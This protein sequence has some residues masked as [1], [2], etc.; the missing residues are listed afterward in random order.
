MRDAIGLLTRQHAWISAAVIVLVAAVANT[1]GGS[2]IDEGLHL[3]GLRD[4]LRFAVGVIGG[5]WQ[6][7]FR[8]IKSDLEYYGVL[9]IL[10][11]YSA[12][13]LSQVLGASTAEY[14]L[15]YRLALH[16][17]ALVW[18]LAAAWATFKIVEIVSGSR[19][20]A[21]LATYAL[22][23]YPMWLGY[24][25]FNYKDLPAAFFFA[26]SIYAALLELEPDAEA[27]RR[28]VLLLAIATIG[29]CTV[30]FAGVVLI[31]PPWLVV[32]YRAMGGPEPKQ[33]LLCLGVAGLAAAFVTYLLT[34]ASWLEPIDFL[35]S[36]L[37]H[38][39]RYAW[40][41]CTLTAQ[42]CLQPSN[43]DWSALSYLALWIWAQIPFAILLLLV[44]ATAFTVIRGDARERLL[45]L[46]MTV[47]VALIVVRNSTLY[48]GLRHVLFVI[49]ILF[50]FVLC[51]T[52]RMICAIP[53]EKWRGSSRRLAMGA[54]VLTL[55]VFVFDNIALFPYNYAYRNEIARVMFPPN[56]FETDYWRFSL[57]QVQKQIQ[58]QGE[59][60]R[61]VNYRYDDCDRRWA[62][63]LTPALGIPNLL[64]AEC[65][66]DQPPG[67]DAVATVRRT[68]FLGRPLVMASIRRCRR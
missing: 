19:R 20:L 30:K 29:A 39:S 2:T 36:N 10:P 3:D 44:P 40:K 59:E 52:Y 55:S 37:I 23:L 62:R 28:A 60:E 12:M 68:P 53:R 6:L 43:A 17:S 51:I 24:A 56:A 63:I 41:G 16:A 15:V 66:S 47:P 25:F 58:A 35:V 45:L 42:R 48:D 32:L 8:E 22:M 57:R 33:R 67:C 50:A 27:F 34:P 1:I 31:F 7:D 13:R 64:I 14:S 49:P 4:T 21:W 46:L 11:A 38:F 61:G 54:Y 65:P 5:D 26:L 9:P 18:S